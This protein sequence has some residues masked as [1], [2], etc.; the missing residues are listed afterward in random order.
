M[1]ATANCGWEDGGI[2]INMS[3]FLYSKLERGTQFEE[4]QVEALIPVEEAKRLCRQLQEAISLY[5]SIEASVE[6]WEQQTG[7]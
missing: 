2:K 3:G 1:K 5:E 7:L 6:S 4:T